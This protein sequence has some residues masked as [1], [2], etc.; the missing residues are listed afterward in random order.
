MQGCALQ[1][2]EIPYWWPTKAEALFHEGQA[3]L[4]VDRA[5]DAETCWQAVVQDDPLHPSPPD[6]LRDGKPAT[7]WPLCHGKS[8]GR[9]GRVVW[10]TYERAGPAD[11]LSLLGMRVRSELERLAPEATIGVLERYVA[12]DPT[13]WEALRALAQAELALG[14][15]EDADR[16][17]QA[18][19]AG[20]R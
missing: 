6:T 1:L 7:P 17:F 10:E 13:D 15:K 3:Y 16:D 11:H 14:R 20:S 19:L 8:L 9:C 12:A 5:K 2:R 18:C 4:M